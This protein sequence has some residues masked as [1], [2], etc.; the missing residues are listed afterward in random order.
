MLRYLNSLF[1]GILLLSTSACS[2]ETFEPDGNETGK[3][4][5]NLKLSLSVDTRAIDVKGEDEN[6]ENKINTLDIYLYESDADG[7]AV[8]K[9][10]KHLQNPASTVGIPLK[11]VTEAFPQTGS[12]KVVAVANCPATTA[13]NA[14]SLNTLKALELTADFRKNEVQKDF[15]MTNFSQANPL[16]TWTDKDGSG[17]I[18]LKRVAAKIR[19]ALDV[20]SSVTEAGKTWTPDKNDMRLFISHGVSKGRL[21]GSQIP[22]A[23][24][25]YYSVVTSGS[26]DGVD[27]TVA[28]KFGNLGAVPNAPESNYTYYNKLPYYSYPNDW[29]ESMFD[30]TRTM[31]T[32]VVPWVNK[33]GGKET[34]LPTYYSIPVND[35]KKLESN[36][37][38]YIR[39]HVGIMGSVTPEK[40]I[41]VDIKCEIADW[42]QADNGT[43]DLRPV[44]YLNFN[45]KEFVM[46]NIEE[47]KIPFES[48]HDC[49]VESFSG[50]FY[51]FYG[52]RGDKI[53]R[54]FG[55]SFKGQFFDYSIDNTN[56]ILKFNHHFFDY[57]KP[58]FS[59]NVLT[60]LEHSDTESRTG[61]NSNPTIYARL[62]SPFEVDITVRHNVGDAYDSSYKETIHLTIYPAVYLDVDY[63]STNGRNN[64]DG[65]IMLNGYAGT[66]DN[67]T[68][69]LSDYGHSIDATDAG[70]LT[71]LK[72]TSLNEEEKLKWVLDDPRTYYINNE[73]SNTSMETDLSDQMD[74]WQ[75]NAGSNARPRYIAGA[76]DGSTSTWSSGECKLI[77]EHF[78]MASPVAWNETVWKPTDDTEARTLKY[79]YPTSELP[80]K[81]NILAPKIMVCS[82]HS[83]SG[84]M[85]RET[86]RRRCAAFQQYG[87]P[88]GRWRLPTGAEIAI[89]KL[90]QKYQRSNDIFY[91][92]ISNNTSGVGTNWSNAGA[93]GNGE[94]FGQTG[95][96]YVRCVYD[97]WYWEK[98]DANGV[99]S[100]R[101]PEG[102][103][104]ENWKKFT[105]GDRPKENLLTRTPTGPTVQEYLQ[106]NAPGNY[107]VVR[108][109][110]KV[111]LEKMN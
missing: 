109:G 111:K 16:A 58:T 97:L 84:S 91:R 57:W 42:G 96:S 6:N 101:I 15:V 18:K 74:V 59:S 40:P 3:G 102:N 5:L 9:I 11:D 108:N 46:N 81:S 27:Y 80:G 94:T 64:N 78:P 36:K 17:D 37:Y 75:Y 98:V 22:L 61:T 95:S 34:Y 83:Y 100:A 76:Y 60:K 87:Y 20:V 44:R 110:D 38:Y 93:T 85:S 82:Y 77:W 50:V 56:H 41:E 73:L 31:L 105:W 45:Q 63:I 7:E 21:D 32:V 39:M 26:K 72:A 2:S 88:A 4:F 35:V 89:F 92:D 30:D 1:I 86:A 104:R 107:I 55:D 51:S 48:T 23:E 68:G 13:M 33:D 67:N 99:S 79:Y 53:K 43:V 106:Q 19:V 24:S 47:I 62:F 103:N 28:R 71:I 8:P 90:I 69:G 49:T 10:Y 65:W 52:A 70:A 25:D 54:T 12:C 29:E 14:P 66:N